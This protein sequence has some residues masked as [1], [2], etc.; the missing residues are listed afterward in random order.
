MVGGA[1]ATDVGT[2]GARVGGSSVCLATRGRSSSG[3]SAA[4]WSRRGKMKGTR[5]GLPPIDSKGGLTAQRRSN[6]GSTENPMCS[7]TWH[8]S[9]GNRR[10]VDSARG[11]F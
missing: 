7:S 10:G 4:G 11:R 3:I 1:G 9:S 5:H 6:R 2:E 8:R